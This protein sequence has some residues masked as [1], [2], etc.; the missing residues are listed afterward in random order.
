MLVVIRSDCAAEPA[1]TMDAEN[2]GAYNFMGVWIIKSIIRSMH[3]F[4]KCKIPYKMFFYAVILACAC[5]Q[6]HMY[7]TDG[8]Y[9][10]DTS[11]E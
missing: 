8:G 2:K 7:C 4:F 10:K 5:S 3:C 11:V 6:K 9:L 1:F